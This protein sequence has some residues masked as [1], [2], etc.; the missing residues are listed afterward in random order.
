MSARA[1]RIIS[2]MVFALAVVSMLVR[3]YL[4][5]LNRA[6]DVPGGTEPDDAEVRS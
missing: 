5:I 4:S 6:V 3:I 1:V 2:W